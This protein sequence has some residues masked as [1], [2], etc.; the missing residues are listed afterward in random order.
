MKWWGHSSTVSTLGQR[1]G[2]DPLFGTAKLLPPTAGSGGITPF[3]DGP[4]SHFDLIFRSRL[5][6][7]SRC[8]V[9]LFSPPFFPLVPHFYCHCHLPPCCVGY[10]L[11]GDAHGGIVIPLGHVPISWPPPGVS[12]GV[13]PQLLVRPAGVWTG[14]G[15]G[16]RHRVAVYGGVPDGSVQITDMKMISGSNLSEK[17]DGGEM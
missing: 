9:L 5:S 13:R 6:D 16:H 12:D 3:A 8:I 14:R 10:F 1:E 17:V 7:F 11:P 4:I 15:G 2:T